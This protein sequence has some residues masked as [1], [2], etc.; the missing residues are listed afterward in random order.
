MQDELKQV[1]EELRALKESREQEREHQIE[2]R[3]RITYDSFVGEAT[4]HINQNL[5]KYP[6]LSE[7]PDNDQLV[8]DTIRHV[9]ENSKDEKGNG[10]FLSIEEACDYL[11]KTLANRYRT[12][13]QSDR[14]RKALGISFADEQQKREGDRQNPPRYSETPQT[15]SSRYSNQSAPPISKRTYSQ[16][17]RADSIKRM[18]FG[19]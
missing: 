14:R 10:R 6:V 9:W 5:D 15:I 1:R 13:L 11:D 3:N 19:E 17:E 7:E 12:A 2:E 16:E 8:F 18:L 4:A